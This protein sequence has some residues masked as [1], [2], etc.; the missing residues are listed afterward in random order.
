MTLK[1]TDSPEGLLLLLKRSCT[2]E[3]G[4]SI[5]MGPLKVQL[6]GR[7]IKPAT[8]YWLLTFGAQPVGKPFIVQTCGVPGCIDPD[9]HVPSRSPH[10]VMADPPEKTTLPSLA[11]QVT[12]LSQQVCEL[13]SLLEEQVELATT[14][15]DKLDRLLSR[16]A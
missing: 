7:L 9:C 6:G 14:L 3:N 12:T 2:I 11:A 16:P 10:G 13:R 8:A 5:Y 15:S 4:H 1:K